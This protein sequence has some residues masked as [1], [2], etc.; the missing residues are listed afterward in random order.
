MALSRKRQHLYALHP[1]IAVIPECSQNCLK[2]CLK[3]GF[4][5]RW[6]GDNPRKGLGVLVAKPFHIARAQKPRSRWVVPLSI[7]KPKTKSALGPTSGLASDDARDFL[8]IAVWTMPVQGSHV[9]SYIGQLYQAVVKNPQ[10]FSGKPAI[11]C[12]DFNS[13]KF[14]DNKRPKNTENAGNHSAVVGLLENHR[15]ASAYHHF[16]SE[17]QG[18]E[19]QPTYYFWH[20]KNRPYH[21]DY[22]FLPQRWAS[23]IKRVE[24]GSHATWSKL[25]D[26]VPLC[27]DVG[28]PAMSKAKLTAGHYALR[29]IC[30][31]PGR[32]AVRAGDPCQDE[33]REV[34]P[35]ATSSALIGTSGCVKVHADADRG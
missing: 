17:S 30:Y 20:H 33:S 2:L 14:W 16:F 24:L 3:D 12:G 23:Q 34:H 13:N 29:G 28:V 15:L 19:T 11:V 27:V 35:K 7:T 9:K 1:D 26:H 18:Q 4:E 5:G 6:F 22:V 10:W 32:G 25:S 8:L 21:I 31:T